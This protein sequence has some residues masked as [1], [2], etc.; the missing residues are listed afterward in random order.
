[1]S[2]A[3]ENKWCKI[4]QVGDHQILVN[5]EGF[6]EEDESY[7]VK[8]TAFVNGC[9]M[10]M[11]LGHVEEDKSDALFNQYDESMAERFLQDS[12]LPLLQDEA[13]SD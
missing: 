9:K 10:S 11:T 6:N 3:E 5:K 1:M 12:V 8:L 7:E 4:F 2:K 13:T